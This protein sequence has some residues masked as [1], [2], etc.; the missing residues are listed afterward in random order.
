MHLD[1]YDAKSR[2]GG[3]HQHQTRKTKNVSRSP[4]DLETYAH[5]DVLVRPIY[6]NGYF[7]FYPTV[8]A[9]VL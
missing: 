6:L 9:N 4:N 2:I 8:K 7:I 1:M 3:R 5:E